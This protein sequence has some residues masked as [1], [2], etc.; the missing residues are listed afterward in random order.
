MQTA[1]T[2]TLPRAE[3]RKVL[4]A[5]LKEAQS[6]FAQ[7]KQ[8]FV[9]FVES[10]W[11]H[12][13]LADVPRLLEEVAGANRMLDLPDSAELLSAV[14]RF[15]AVELVQHRRVPNAQQMDTLADALASL[16]YYLE[17]VR[18]QRGERGKILELARERLA[19]LGY[20]PVPS[21]ALNAPETEIPVAGHEVT[22]SDISHEPHTLP[23]AQTAGEAHDGH[24][25]ADLVLDS[26]VPERRQTPDLASL[27]AVE[28]VPGADLTDLVVGEAAAEALSPAREVHDL[29][30]FKPA[31]TE[32]T[33]PPATGKELVG[34]QLGVED[35]D[36]EIREVFVEEVQEEIDNLRQLLPT[37][38]GSPDDVE[39]LK[40]IRRV[41]HTLKGSGRLVG[42]MVLGEFAWKI[43]NM[44]NRV[45]D[46]SIPARPEV[47]GLVAEARDVLPRLLA[48]LRGEAGHYAD[49]EGIEQVADALAAGQVVEYRPAA[50]AVEQTAVVDLVETPAAS[51]VEPS[52]ESDDIAPTQT[53]IEVAVPA[54]AMDPSDAGAIER[55]TD[56]TLLAEEAIDLSPEDAAAIH[57]FLADAASRS[58]PSVAP[59]R[60][61]TVDTDADADEAGAVE[62]S[63]VDEADEVTAELA[64]DE[65]LSL[66]PGEQ[67][68][69]AGAPGF[70]LPA[71]AERTSEFAASVDVVA[72]FELAEEGA[73][74]D[75]VLIDPDLFEILKAEVAGHL[76]TVEAYLQRSQGQPQAVEEPLLR[77]V[78]TISGAFAMTEVEVGTEL[79]WPLEGYIKRLLAQAAAPSVI[80]FECIE[81]AAQ[82]LRALMIELDQPMPRPQRHTRLARRISALRD[83]LPEPTRPVI[84]VGIDDDLIIET[85]AIPGMAPAD[86]GGDALTSGDVPLPSADALSTGDVAEPGEALAS[87]RPPLEETV[88]FDVNAFEGSGELSFAYELESSE[89]FD[90]EAQAQSA[91]LEIIETEG[92]APSPYWSDTGSTPV[93]PSVDSGLTLDELGEAEAAD[94]WL[95]EFERQVTGEAAL[96][97]SAVAGELTE[98]SGAASDSVGS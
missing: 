25:A 88:A 58:E 61:E 4:E 26:G 60:V 42:A 54:A 47:V 85:Q 22:A 68:A 77:A 39:A 81:E 52:Q 29:A 20:W 70:D 28:V 7:A 5:V 75:L 13:Q 27:A 53:D 98:T 95:A 93:Q 2:D 14:G 69:E 1:S 89:P 83:A 6:N 35:I 31:Q 51:A 12:A 76:D 16:E 78:H 38:Q 66:E 40:P 86:I 50:P 46:K 92:G 49:L 84:D 97:P 63:R 18:D 73:S 57:A 19:Q 11:D 82:A 71:D 74:G 96:Q 45:L 72:G 9:A 80:G 37:W 44:L 67:D 32:T 34:F 36:E 3:A 15:T 41:F 64:V 56:A 91:D 30:G 17:S 43:E 8:C 21:H 65:P 59:E 33:R 79:A 62:R 87:A 24:A 48:A 90:P 23:R 94:A 55:P 10:N